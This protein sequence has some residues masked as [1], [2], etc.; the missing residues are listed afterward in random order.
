MGGN[1]KKVW[2][3]TSLHRVKVINLT[4]NVTFNL[5]EFSKFVALKLLKCYRLTS[6]SVERTKID[7]YVTAMV[8][9]T[10]SKRVSTHVKRKL[11]IYCDN[12]KT[13]FNPLEKYSVVQSEK[14]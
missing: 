10:F 11:F 2:I 1:G 14:Q 4:E 3:S 12:C 9:P 8:S 7:M 6:L 5:P 13:R